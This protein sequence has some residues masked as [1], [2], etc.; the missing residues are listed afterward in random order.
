MNG[1]TTPF[2]YESAQTVVTSYFVSTGGYNVISILV[3]VSTTPH[4]TCPIDAYPHESYP[5]LY[6]DDD[7]DDDAASTDEKS[8]IKFGTTIITTRMRDT[9]K[10]DIDWTFERESWI[11]RIFLFLLVRVV[12][13][14]VRV[15]VLLC[16]I[17]GFL[18]F[19]F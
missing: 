12:V 10:D 13:E 14:V 9:R 15:I 2:E 3:T 1:S 7:D 19:G 8:T 6:D 17:V 4:L 16:T 5:L 11:V 18:L